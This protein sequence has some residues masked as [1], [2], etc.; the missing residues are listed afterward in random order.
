MNIFKDDTLY[1]VS[2]QRQI[3]IQVQNWICK[4]IPNLLCPM[5]HKFRPKIM[6]FANYKICFMLESTIKMKQKLVHI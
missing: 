2:I 1:V 6:S 3:Q 5:T 4:N